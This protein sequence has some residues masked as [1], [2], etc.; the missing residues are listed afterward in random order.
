MYINMCVCTV[1]MYGIGQMLQHT[2]F[3]ESYLPAMASNASRIGHPIQIPCLLG[4]WVAHHPAHA[5]LFLSIL[6]I[7]CLVT[8]R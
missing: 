6:Y 1:N 8:V 2:Y 7:G 5:V 3:M 4:A